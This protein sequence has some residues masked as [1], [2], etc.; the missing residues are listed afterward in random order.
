MRGRKKRGDG[1]RRVQ[2]YSLDFF[3]LVCENG[4]VFVARRCSQYERSGNRF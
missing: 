1:L 2:L 4:L 3:L